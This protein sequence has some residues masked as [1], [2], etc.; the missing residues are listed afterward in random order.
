MVFPGFSG[1]LPIYVSPEFRRDTSRNDFI[2]ST[3]FSTPFQHHTCHLVTKK[4]FGALLVCA[5]WFLRE[6]SPAIRR[7]T[8]QS[9]KSYLWISRE[10]FF[11][12]TVGSILNNR[13]DK[14]SKNLVIHMNT[15]TFLWFI[16]QRCNIIGTTRRF[17]SSVY[18]TLMK[19]L[20]FTG[21]SGIL[22]CA[23]ILRDVKKVLNKNSAMFLWVFGRK[24]RKE[25]EGID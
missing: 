7:T 23:A 22:Y 25:L 24:F 5:V 14:T 9:F 13:F 17:S 21:S 18:T 4:L 12:F 6:L 20:N 15:S 16:N 3:I 8:R 11:F 2:I 19:F 1:F 10:N